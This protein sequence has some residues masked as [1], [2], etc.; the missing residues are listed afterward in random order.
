MTFFV[1][2]WFILYITVQRGSCW[3]HKW[4][5]HVLKAADLYSKFS[6]KCSVHCLYG[7][8]N[9]RAIII[10]LMCIFEKE[11]VKFLIVCSIWQLVRARIV[12]MQICFFDCILINNMSCTMLSDLLLWQHM[13]RPACTSKS[14]FCMLNAILKKQ[15]MDGFARLCSLF[16]A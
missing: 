10:V 15:Q 13:L 3:K 11:Y 12:L 5:Y 2:H 1:V 6:F 7:P 9:L 14:L 4:M 8:K 16:L